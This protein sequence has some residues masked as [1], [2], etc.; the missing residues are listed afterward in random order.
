MRLTD[1]HRA[2]RLPRGAA[3]AVL[4]LAAA[5]LLLLYSLYPAGD[6]EARAGRSGGSSSR[7]YRS[8]SS[9]SSSRSY[10]S[11]SRHSSYGGYSSSYRRSYPSSYGGGYYS[12]S[13]HFTSAIILFVTFIVIA[14]IGALHYLTSGR[15]G[16]PLFDISPSS[17]GVFGGGRPYGAGAGCGGYGGGLAG[18]AASFIAGAQDVDRPDL[19]ELKERVKEVFMRIQDAW[20]ERDI[21]YADGYASQRF[22]YEKSSEID[23]MLARGERNILKNIRIID[24]RIVEA[25]GGGGPVDGGLEPGTGYGGDYSSSGRMKALI[26]ASMIDYAVDEGSGR[27]I[28]GDE[29]VPDEFCEQWN[30][31]YNENGWVADE[32]VQID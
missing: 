25:S 14:V 32:I 16:R 17:G 26:R 8:S 13:G 20:T 31:I 19:Y 10:S 9:Y 11:S 18:A 22:Y 3:L 7:S 12:R 5:A 2:R 29:F 1:G 23:D 6:A 21:S 24:V 28:K 30:F 15:G 4:P 27:V